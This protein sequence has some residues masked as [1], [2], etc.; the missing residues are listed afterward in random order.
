MSGTRRQFLAALGAASV[1]GI[2]VSEPGLAAD[3]SGSYVLLT[4][5]DKAQYRVAGT[6]L[7]GPLAIEAVK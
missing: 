6:S 7:S 1:L 3:S 5:A 2:E 4:A